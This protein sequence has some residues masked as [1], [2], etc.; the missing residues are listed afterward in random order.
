MVARLADVWRIARNGLAFA[1]FGASALLFA[2]VLIPA[3]RRSASGHE[4]PDLHAQR[5]LH[6]GAR[7][8]MRFLARLGMVQLVVH[9]ADRLRGAGSR[10][11]VANHPTLFDIIVLTSLLPQAD[12]IVNVD[13]S[14]NPFLRRL[15]SIAGYIPNDNGIQVVNECV[16]RLRAGRTVVVFP[17]G[18]RSPEGG[19]GAFRPGTAL[20][21][22]RSGEHP[23][24]V[25]LTCDPPALAKGKSWYDIPRG[26]LHVTARVGEPLAPA[27]GRG[28]AGA[29]LPA[30]VERRS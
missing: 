9:G 13:R 23:L 29:A 5:L 10:L 15:V 4:L 8:Y 30:G 16:R 11:V 21:A 18:T 27:N 6:S 26:P 28:E 14:R 19:L 3:A 20:I 12:G 7:W 1:T 24:P 25:L 17:E 22:L 2:F